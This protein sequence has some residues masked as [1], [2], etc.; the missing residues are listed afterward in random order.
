MRYRLI[1]LLLVAV[2]AAVIAVGNDRSRALNAHEVLVAETAGEMLERGDYLVPYYNG[3]IRL[4]KPPL[5]YW[6]TLASHRLGG[7]PSET[8]VSELE[9]RIPSLIC[10]S[11]APARDVRARACRLR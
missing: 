11:A 3:L 6:L 2:T 10:G 5:A 9:A 4:E 1:V 7:S 8:R